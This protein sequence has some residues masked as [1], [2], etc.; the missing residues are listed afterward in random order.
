MAERLA[1][2]AE[3]KEQALHAG[4]EK[5]VERQHA[6]GKM[7]ARERIDYLL[8]EGSFQELDMLARHRAHGMG[9]EDNRPYTDGVV[10]GFGM[11]GPSGY[12]KASDS[13][14]ASSLTRMTLTWPPDF[15]FPNR[16]SSASGF[17]MYSW[18]TRDIGRAPMS[19]S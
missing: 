10:T 1:Q 16:T 15:S 5:S 13:A 11:I 7:T 8:D 6:K 2:L 12:S 14:P 19:S 17:F 4:S 9:L 3:R 18:I